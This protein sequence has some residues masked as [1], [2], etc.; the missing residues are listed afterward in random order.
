MWCSVEGELEGSFYSRSEAV[1][2][3]GI[4][5]V[6]ITARQWPNG[7]FRRLGI[8][9]LVYLFHPE[10]KLGKT[11]ATLQALDITAHG[12]VGGRERALR[13]SDHGDGATVCTGKETS[14]RRPL[15]VWAVPDGSV[16]Q[17]WP[18]LAAR[19]GSATAEDAG[20]GEPRR[21]RRSRPSKRPCGA[22][23]KEGEQ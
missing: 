14:T 8:N 16:L 19:G 10:A 9:V 13:F 7:G 2:V 17:G 11:W 4:T 23:D 5:P 1:T 12:H 15:V 20:A 22:L 21:H 3:N 6:A 18:L